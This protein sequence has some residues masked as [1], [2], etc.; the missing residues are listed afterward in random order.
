[1]SLTRS[2]FAKYCATLPA[3]TLH[4]QWDA[5]VAKVGGKVFALHGDQL[6]G[7]VF[8]VSAL[9]FEG[10]TS[11]EGVGQAAY[12]AKGQWVD[13][14]RGA[15]LSARDVKAY[16]A[17]SHRVIATKLTRKVRAELGID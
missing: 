11:L 13:V 14:A 6:G 9:G 3:A 16:I 4:E 17:E 8:K 2:A 10:L 12:F 1:M 7:V 15:D 5:L